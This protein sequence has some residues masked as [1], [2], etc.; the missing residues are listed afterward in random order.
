LNE[1]VLRQGLVD[2]QLE[3]GAGR[4][5]PRH[6]FEMAGNQVHAV[7]RDR[8]VGADGDD[9]LVC[10]FEEAGF[11]A[12]VF[13]MPERRHQKHRDTDADH[14]DGQQLPEDRP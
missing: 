5:I 6:R 1:L 11:V 12:L 3:T 7:E 10:Q 2:H 8:D 9:A 13:E 14:G 4:G